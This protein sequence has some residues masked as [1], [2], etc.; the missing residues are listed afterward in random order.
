M[1]QG[2]TLF[3]VAATPACGSC[4]SSVVHPIARSIERAAA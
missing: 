1:L 3:H 2:V 4:R